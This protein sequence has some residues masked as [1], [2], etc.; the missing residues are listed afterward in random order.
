MKLRIL[1]YGL[2]I[3]LICLVATLYLV[4]ANQDRILEAA[5]YKMTT[6]ARDR[7]D[8]DLQLGGSDLVLY[9]NSVTFNNVV[10]GTKDKR[11]S[12]KIGKVELNYSLNRLLKGE[13]HFGKIFIEGPSLEI[14]MPDGREG[15]GMVESEGLDSLLAGL[16]VARKIEIEKGSLVLRGPEM[17][18]QLLIDGLGLQLAIGDEA[19]TAK[20]WIDKCNIDYEMYHG[21]YRKGFFQGILDN[22]GLR[23]DRLDLDS[24]PGPLKASGRINPDLSMEADFLIDGDLDKF[25]YS[26]EGALPMAGLVRGKGRFT[27][28]NGEWDIK[29]RFTTSGLS[30][31]G[32]PIPDSAAEV[33]L[34]RNRCVFSGIES[35]KGMDGE[36]EGNG[37]LRWSPG[38]FLYSFDINAQ[39]VDPSSVGYV[40]KHFSEEFYKPVKLVSG[41]IEIG[42]GNEVAGREPS[43]KV[44]LD[45][46]GMVDKYFGNQKVHVSG[47][48][49]EGPDGRTNLKNFQLAA[50]AL[51]A[52][53]SG[54]ID[55]KEGAALA[56]IAET[57]D[58]AASLEPY[59]LGWI[60]GMAGFAGDIL[61]AGESIT[62]T[63]GIS[64]EPASIR[65]V[66]FDRISGRIHYEAGVFSAERLAVLKNDGKAE[67]SG[68][69]DHGENDLFDAGLSVKRMN[70]VDAGAIIGIDLPLEGT[71]SGDMVLA[72]TPD[73]VN[74]RAVLS[75][76]VVTIEGNEIKQVESEFSF[77]PDGIEFKKLEGLFREGRISYVGKVN[78]NNKVE[79]KLKTGFSKIGALLPE[80]LLDGALEVEGEISGSLPDPD[81]T[82]VVSLRG[83]RYMDVPY[84]DLFMKLNKRKDT[85]RGEG[86]LLGVIQVQ[87]EMG[88]Q[89]PFPL[90]G[91]ATFKELDVRELL[92][93]LHPLLPPGVSEFVKPYGSR[94]TGMVEF[95]IPLAEPEGFRGILSLEEARITLGDET[96][97]LRSP[98]KISFSRDSLSVE[99]LGFEG[100]IHRF[101]LEGGIEKSLL[102]LRME[103]ILD[104]S[105][106]A[107]RYSRLSSV[108]IKPDISLTV[109]G[110]MTSPDIRGL[111]RIRGGRLG[112]PWMLDID[113]LDGDIEFDRQTI[114]FKDFGA[115]IGNNNIAG[116]GTYSIK[117]QN[118]ELL[119]R[120][121]LPLSSA[122][123]PI[124]GVKEYS[125]DAGFE[126]VI[127]GT[128]GDPDIEADVSAAG[129]LVRFTNL[130]A[131]LREIALR[132][133]ISDEY[134]RV[135]EASAKL[136]G[137][138]VEGSGYIVWDPVE[139]MSDVNLDL[140]AEEIYVYS[141]DTMKMVTTADLNFQGVPDEY[142][143]SGRLVLV[144]GKY[145]KD[146]SPRPVISL[147]QETDEVLRKKS[148]EHPFLSGLILNLHIVGEEGFWID[149]NV[150]QINTGV[151]IRVTGTPAEPVMS[152]DIRVQKGTIYYLGKKFDLDE[153]SI[154]F[155]EKY[156]PDPYINVQAN[157]VI[158]SVRI[159][160]IVQGTIDSLN[161]DLY[162]EPPYSRE[163]IVSLITLGAPRA[164]LENRG[165]E[166]SALGAMVV[167]SGA[168]INRIE[169][170]ARDFTGLEVFQIEPTL[171]DSGGAARV[172]MGKKLSD[173]IFL[174]YSRNLT[175]TGDEQFSMEYQ[176][177]DFLSLVGKQDRTGIYSFDL[178]SSFEGLG[179]F[180]Y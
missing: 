39:K 7:W 146:I 174:S 45:L 83:P 86:E 180:R 57:S 137:G 144:R 135:R 168:F 118:M 2:L 10:L 40:K 67:L 114:R 149:N 94:M 65:G 9:R 126:A 12:L 119:L 29:G 27:L 96:S 164:N 90:E 175:T 159:N 138:E 19:V 103:G 26:L 49:D 143:L 3:I 33:S 123:W 147:R 117:D 160:L 58:L 36:F 171:S 59:G 18:N 28:D 87:L 66:D 167:F 52:S 166:V 120:G 17:K 21:L 152:G 23:I 24:E 178:V 13:V 77:D 82:G 112:L 43:W 91:R 47:M 79:G 97:V 5:R 134:I 139:I 55:E 37:E 50:G 108:S 56:L 128:P 165:R 133:S 15:K 78:R 42:G 104:L 140:S 172:V 101:V 92:P 14:S 169:D 98:A 129:G 106:L 179:W 93:Y 80:M 131:P 61:G 122:R 177:L 22:D 73:D 130:N 142:L 107:E 34:D 62:V 102:S 88:L 6:M 44:S 53:W 31:N 156:P 116:S 110:S 121:T 68:A 1:I 154:I 124:P 153:A 132:V 41:S 74:G 109:T 111:A 48:L 70:L 54:S 4:Y 148:L 115:K 150:A 99:K 71:F 127:T 60:D 75:S 105:F 81:F 145:F 151:D 46:A 25:R 20:A 35:Q 63:G 72:G 163:D 8:I 89:A 125:V 51:K 157:T 85:I 176:L 100:D 32:E 95:G 16:A 158:S 155:P 170:Q 38:V 84:P 141:P 173:R 136:N 11:L 30:I 161:L 113:G 76:P 64:I 69:I 162:S